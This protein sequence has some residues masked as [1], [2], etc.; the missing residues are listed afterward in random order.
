MVEAVSSKRD[1]C[2]LRLSPV[3]AGLDSDEA[4]ALLKNLPNIMQNTLGH[5]AAVPTCQDLPPAHMHYQE[6]HNSAGIPYYEV[7]I[8]FVSSR[9][10]FE[11]L[12]AIMAVVGSVIL[13]ISG[14]SL[15]WVASFLGLASICIGI[16][17]FLHLRRGFSRCVNALNNMD[18]RYLELY[19]A[20]ER[21]E[22]LSTSY[23]R[24][25]PREF[26]KLLGRESILN[27]SLGDAMEADITVMFSDIR[28]FTALS[29]K[30]SAIN[31]FRLLNSY[32][33]RI[34]P[35]IG[36]NGGFIDKYMGD[37]IMALFPTSPRSAILAATA[38]VNELKTYNEHR[39]SSGYDPISIG[40]GLNYGKT[41]LGTIG[42]PLEMSGTVI[43]DCVNVAARLE[44][45]GKDFGANILVSNET[46]RA[47]GLAAEIRCRRLGKV[48]VRGKTQATDVYEIY[49]GSTESRCEALDKT[50][51]RFE[52]AVDCLERREF[53]E[54]IALFQEVLAASPEDMASKY[55]LNSINVMRSRRAA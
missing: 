16:S 6:Y 45:L 51:A 31:N 50:K 42:H 27:V 17:K 1:Y 11:L 26:L 47:S 9:K 22:K 55:I 37:G 54:A 19:E 46:L 39:R 3:L 43:S 28:N 49:E 52:R 33:Q 23:S 29:E 44:K 21:Y 34:S 14:L 36:N 2:R 10:G 40:I 18:Q 25:V 41:I 7:D 20:K 30:I 53:D 13:A 5:Y 4:Q 12:S 35:L 38:M 15:I 48:A 32:L 24:F 8:R